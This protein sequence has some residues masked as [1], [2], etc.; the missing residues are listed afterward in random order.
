[1]KGAAGSS[2]NK[3]KTAEHQLN[4]SSD[5]ERVEDGKRNRRSVWSIA[6]KPYK[7]AHFAVFPTTLVEPCILTGSRPGD[8]VLDPFAGSGTTA[9]V[10]R[11]H[12]RNSI[13]CELNADYVSLAQA[14]I[15]A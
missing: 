3:G 10:A 6:T 15:A 4:R 9:V 12:G 2:F 5:A 13:L 7:G 11:D 8:V 14:R 1:M